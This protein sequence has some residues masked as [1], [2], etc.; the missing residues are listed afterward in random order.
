MSLASVQRKLSGQDARNLRNLCGISNGEIPRR[1]RPNDTGLQ[2]C[3]ETP[4]SLSTSYTCAGAH[5]HAGARGAERS[6]RDSVVS[7]DSAPAPP[8]NVTVLKH[9]RC[10]DCRCWIGEPYNE[11]EHG[12]IRN[13]CKMP[14]ELP[15]EAWHYCALYHGPQI[16]KDVLVWPKAAH[17]APRSQDAGQGER[18]AKAPAYAN[19]GERD[20]SVA[21]APPTATDATGCNRYFHADES[22][23]TAAGTVAGLGTVC[24]SARK[25]TERKESP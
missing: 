16:S 14:P 3:A 9:C 10:I 22:K 13:G 7:R 20:A 6:E 8:R 25:T 24:F 4:E 2:S 18:K 15:A 5:T 23:V 11:C 17:V 21:D 1:N 12:I 19:G